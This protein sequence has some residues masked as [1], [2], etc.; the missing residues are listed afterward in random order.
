MLDKRHPSLSTFALGD[1]QAAA[2]SSCLRSH[3]LSP[4]E[5]F[6]AQALLETK[7]LALTFQSLETV[8]CLCF[9]CFFFSFNEWLSLH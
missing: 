4:S 8:F 2:A 9:V 7:Q 3:G 1:A 5:I 6:S